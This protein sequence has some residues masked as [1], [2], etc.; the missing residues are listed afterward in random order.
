MPDNRTSQR[1]ALAS[2]CLSMLMPSLD[3]SI[4][5]AAL[6]TL[7]RAFSASFH[8]AQWIILAYLI[9]ITALIV[10]AGRLGDLVG[11]RRLLLAGI[12]T[13][14]VASLLCGL[15]PTLALLVAARTAQGLGAAIMLSLTV[16]MVSDT[17]PAARTGSAMGLIGTM[18]AIGTT[19]GPSLGG[20]MIATLGWR[21]LF[22]VNVPLGILNLVLAHRFLPADRPR[23]A[24]PFIRLSMLRAPTLAS[25]L[26]M[27]A[28]VSTV[29]MSTL[30][31]GPF[32]LSRALGLQ[33][34]LMGLALSVGPLAAALAG[35][36]A[37]RLVDRL[38]ATA[39]V[40]AGL[41]GMTIGCL[42]LAAPNST[43]TVAGYL[44]PL[45][46]ITASYA[47]FQAANNTSIMASA[48]SDE[49]GLVSGLVS[50]SRNLGLIA[51]A[52]VMG[53]VFASAS[54]AVEISSA[55]AT[56]V[57]TGMRIT[58]A[59]AAALVVVALGLAF[60]SAHESLAPRPA[61]P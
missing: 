51:G 41:V 26:A 42:T 39:M 48:R 7:A 1:L 33:P 37:G 6:P 20:V 25:A 36:P 10:F 59:A 13:F 11:R 16:A 9:A 18:S 23:V 4:A 8:S 43:P 57:V 58:F 53:A 21:S 30:V 54:G 32:Y 3:T 38:G 15:A 61:R 27:T 14:T 60:S 28:I 19:L 56:S 2:L 50:L 40:R 52:S 29:I 46:A 17:V 55:P 45:V 31:V 22:L 5:N 24:S 34:A 49:R 47:L 35:I 12:A 44:I